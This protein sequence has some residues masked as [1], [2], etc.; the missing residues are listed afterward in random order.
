MASAEGLMQ[1]EVAYCPGPNVCDLVSLSLP[2]GTTAA[3]ALAA[4]GLREKHALGAVEVL[5]LGVWS[6][7]REAT[8]VLR[9]GDRL[10]IYRPLLVDPKEARRQ[11]YQQHKESLAKRLAAKAAAAKAS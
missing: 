10:E 8:S 4:S 1:V 11:R 3:Q 6:K 5:R 2:A 9:Q 7:P